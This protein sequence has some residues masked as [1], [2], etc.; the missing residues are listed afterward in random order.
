MGSLAEDRYYRDLL[1]S[2]IDS[3]KI[4]DLKTT[5]DKKNL[6]YIKGI[7]YELE[8]YSDPFEDGSRTATLKMWK[9]F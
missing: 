6:I 3:D 1:A 2:E 8:S 7:A 9:P 4:N 5:E